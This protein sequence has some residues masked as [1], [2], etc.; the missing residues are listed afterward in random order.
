M[1]INRDKHNKFIVESFKPVQIQDSTQ[2]NNSGTSS[3]QSQSSTQGSNSQ[4]SGS[5]TI[6]YQGGMTWA[7]EQKLEGIE[8]G[9][10][11]N[12]N[13]FS[14]ITIDNNGVTN[15]LPADQQTDSFTIKSNTPIEL[16]LVDDVIQI[17]YIWP[18]P[19]LNLNELL[20][21]DSTNL[22]NEGILKF[23]T[24]TS[25]WE[26][27]DGSDLATR[28]WV[29]TQLEPYATQQYVI[30]KIDEL[31]GAA[32]GALDTLEELAQALGDDPNF[33]TTVTNLIAGVDDRN[34][35]K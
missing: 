13:A 9:A 21:V 19:I 4:S 15:Q 34:I 28:T 3:N 27:V 1:V 23:N 2:D 17:N 32:P 11:V 30:N 31:I 26:I 25:K 12:Q 6:I 29:L 22:I 7:Q 8:E 10:Q 14:F 24:T 33:A 35:D 18:E 16:T 5:T 20:D